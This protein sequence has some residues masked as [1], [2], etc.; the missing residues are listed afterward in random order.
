MA[1]IGP[2]CKLRRCEPAEAR[3]RSLGVVVD[4]PCFDDPS[5]VGQAAEQML[6]EAFVAQAAIEGFDEAVLGRLA[7]RDVTPLTRWSCCQASDA[8]EVSS[9]PLSLTIMQGL[10]RPWMS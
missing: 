10:P 2:C 1:Q 8:R 9:V 6:V 3:V 4:L 7:G 5:R